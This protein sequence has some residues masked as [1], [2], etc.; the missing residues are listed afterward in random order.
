MTL[1]FLSLC[2]INACS[3]NNDLHYLLR[4]REFDSTCVATETWFH[5]AISN[6]IILDS[7]AYRTDSSVARGGGG[8]YHSQ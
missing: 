1:H 5:S 6:G 8:V 2:G 3:L 4:S 7:C